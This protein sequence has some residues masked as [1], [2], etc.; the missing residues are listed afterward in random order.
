M[1]DAK[2]D[3]PHDYRYSPGADERGPP[4][5]PTPPSD[6]EQSGLPALFEWIQ[7]RPE[8]LDRLKYLH[9]QHQLMGS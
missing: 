2:H 1:D 6:P 3:A 9:K 8:L 5:G 7:T 4:H